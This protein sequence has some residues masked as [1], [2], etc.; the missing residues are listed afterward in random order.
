MRLPVAGVAFVALMCMGCSQKPKISVLIDDAKVFDDCSNENSPKT[1]SIT[2]SQSPKRAVPKP[3]R[4]Q[5]EN[6]PPCR[7]QV[8][9]RLREISTRKNV[10]VVLR[11]TTAETLPHIALAP[12]LDD[13]FAHDPSWGETFRQDKFHRALRAIGVGAGP[14][15]SSVEF[16]L[17]A[18]PKFVAVRM[19]AS[20]ELVALSYGLT[21]GSNLLQIQKTGTSD[22][23][24]G[25]IKLLDLFRGSLPDKGQEKW[26]L[27]A[28]RFVFNDDIRRFANNITLNRWS[29]YNRHLLRRILQL[30]FAVSRVAWLWCAPLFGILVFLLIA[31]LLSKLVAGILASIG[32]KWLALTFI[33]AIE[34]AAIL[35]S[36]GSLL[37]ISRQRLEDQMFVESL[38]NTDM[39]QVTR[40][41]TGQPL[42][43]QGQTGFVW[44]IPFALVGVLYAVYNAFMLDGID[45]AISDQ[46][47]DEMVSSP[48]KYLLLFAYLPFAISLVWTKTMLINMGFGIPALI[49]KIRAHDS[50]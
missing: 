24:S 20:T 1:A 50:N 46:A 8:E 47:T 40:F 28:W 42:E 14:P 17:I 34:L 37:L 30:Q 45:N 49:R 19:G 7:S 15:G 29:F 12:Y 6:R 31:K 18:D 3:N 33:V 5:P 38:L 2:R 43:F 23:V 11:T 9:E 32:G 39:T 25:T 10:D 36:A 41:F 35:P 4:S 13:V 44:A 48:I 21:S 26:T 22:P 16:I 27:K